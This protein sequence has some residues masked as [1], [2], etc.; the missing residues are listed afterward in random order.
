MQ[1]K[2]QKRFILLG[3]IIVLVGILIWRVSTSYA[4]V[5]QGY[6]GKNVISGDRWGVNITEI[7][8]IKKEGNAV[9]SKEVSTIG[10]TLNFDVVLFKPGDSVSFDVTVQNTSSLKAELYALTL[11]GL[12]D[13]DAENINYTIV[14][15]DSS[16][17][18]ED[19]N[20]GSII[21]SGEEQ[22]FNIT[23]EYD[24]TQNDVNREYHLSL[25]ST[26]IYKQK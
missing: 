4:Y 17:L 10:T 5:N 6:T 2:V 26:I 14:P 7:G 21:K 22:V 20:E 11:V 13:I 16:L 9:L 12:N 8:E 18:H 25:G 19:D 24:N 1:K 15:V 23:V 3:I